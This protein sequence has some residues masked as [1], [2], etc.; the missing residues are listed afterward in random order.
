MPEKSP[1]LEPVSRCPLCGSPERGLHLGSTFEEFSSGDFKI[2]DSHYGKRWHFQRCRQCGFVYA[3]P[4]PGAE[5]L[6][7]IYGS[8]EDPEYGSE[9]EGRG[10]NFSRILNR[11]ER[12]NLTGKRLLDMGAATGLFVS[13]ARKK[14]WS[15]EGVE[16]SRW[17][18]ET[19][20]RQ[21]GVK[22]HLGELLSYPEKE[23]F[24]VVT[25]LDL[26]EHL[27]NP[28]EALEKARRLLKPGG[29]LVVVTPNVDSFAACLF[30]GRWWHYRP[31]HILF[32]SGKT[33]PLFFR[34]GGFS[35]LK[36]YPFHWTFSLRYLLSRFS[37]GK[38]ICDKLTPMSKLLGRLKVKL[39]LF[40]S[41]EAYARKEG[42]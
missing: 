5:L 28:R 23:L 8:L 38:W 29:I 15:A 1:P 41:L 20:E 6:N 18:V 16:P 25:M 33:L 9:E 34:Q 27:P 26:V 42:S 13:I 39:F 22:L 37:P 21:Y 4:C 31:P 19:A 7:L 30:S 36:V 14:G 24:D 40:D 2:T 17:A 10:A 3:D 12:L 35:P 11:L 32:F